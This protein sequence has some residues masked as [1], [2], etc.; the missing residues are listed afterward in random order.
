MPTPHDPWPP[1]DGLTHVTQKSE[2]LKRWLRTDPEVR[3][4]V[5]QEAF[6]KI[7]EQEKDEHNVAWCVAYCLLIEMAGLT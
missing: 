6:E 2:S 4:H 1:G 3:N 7:H 5:L